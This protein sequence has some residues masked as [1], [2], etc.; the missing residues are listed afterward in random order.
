MDYDVRDFAL[1]MVDD[2]HADARDML[3]ACIKYM[4][5]DAVKD[6]LRSNEYATC[7]DE[8]YSFFDEDA[9]FEEDGA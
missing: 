2:G 4:S 9:L 3:L 8:I 5:A 1:E 7:E 6:M